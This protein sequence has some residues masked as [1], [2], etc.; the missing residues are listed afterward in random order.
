MTT[1]DLKRID[2]RPISDNR[3]E[4]RAFMLVWNDSLRLEVR[5]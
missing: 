1:A 2:S 3:Q 5:R 4:I